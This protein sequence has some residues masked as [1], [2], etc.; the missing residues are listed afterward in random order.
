[1][2]METLIMKY[3][4]GTAFA[5]VTAVFLFKVG[6]VVVMAAKLKLASFMAANEW[7]KNAI[8]VLVP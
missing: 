5:V 4:L 3:T 1:M 7:I 6:F 2:D 8:D